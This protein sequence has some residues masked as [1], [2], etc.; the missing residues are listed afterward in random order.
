MYMDVDLST[1]LWSFLPLVAPLATG[2]SDVAIGS[3]LLK[4]AMVTRQWKREV[5]S[6]CYNLL[7]KAMFGNGFS[8]AQCGFKAVKRGVARKLLAEVEDDEWFFDTE[9]LLLAEERGYRLSEVPV[10]WIEDLDSRVKIAS[11]ALEDVKG[12]LRVKAE[13]LRHRLSRRPSR[14]A[15]D[16][17]EHVR[18]SRPMVG[19]T[20]S[21]RKRGER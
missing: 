1:N 19:A 9:L 6:R 20:V 14:D 2:H 4:G 3:R 13:R 8:D 12:L 15:L 7:V 5:I 18:S 10:D 11:T 21:V 16:N 17:A